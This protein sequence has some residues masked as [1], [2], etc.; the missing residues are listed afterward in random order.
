[1]KDSIYM[2]IG[3]DTSDGTKVNWGYWFSLEEAEKRV[4]N[5]TT[6]LYEGCYDTIVIERV[7][8]GIVPNTLEWFYK[9]NKE[10]ECYE[11]IPIPAEC[12]HNGD[13]FM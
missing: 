13:Y 5:N 9:W 1:M 11:P 8:P 10:N 2:I 3:M 4:L 12:I 6:D 7:Y